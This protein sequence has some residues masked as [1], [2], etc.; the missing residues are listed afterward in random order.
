M[1]NVEASQRVLKAL[2]WFKKNQFITQR[3]KK[4]QFITQR[5]QLNSTEQNVADKCVKLVIF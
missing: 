2:C 5:S 1:E 3:S 4:N